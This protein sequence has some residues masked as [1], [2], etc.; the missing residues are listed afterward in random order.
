MNND[1]AH[2]SRTV[3][4]VD[5]ELFFRKLLG[6]ILT[7]EGFTV[8]AE[9]ADGDEAVEL[10]QRHR[11]ALSILDIYMPRKNGFDA[12]REILSFD[13]QARVLICSGLGY[14]EDV[15]AALSLG[16]RDV[17]L[18]PFIRD[19]VIAIVARALAE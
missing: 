15:N 17:I 13:S 6:N 4:I 2:G 18:K 9:G 16:A 12:T 19:E 11:P 3:M 10:Y 7:E 5:D 1:A 8:V 14:D